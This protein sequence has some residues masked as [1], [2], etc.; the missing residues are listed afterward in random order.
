MKERGKVLI[1]EDL[2]IWYHRLIK[3]YQDN[4]FFVVHVR[5]KKDALNKIMNEN[6]HFVSVDLQ[7]N[8]NNLVEED[9][10]GWDILRAAKKI[11]ADVVV[12]SGF[13]GIDDENIRKAVSKEFGAIFFM[14]KTKYNKTE[15]ID[16]IITIVE[17]HD[18]RFKNDHRGNL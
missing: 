3:L 1:V 5:T 17:H 7:L 12:L 6:F 13:P 9:F 14:N 2:E 16:H 11:F 18:Y 8:T 10:S 4:G 15:M